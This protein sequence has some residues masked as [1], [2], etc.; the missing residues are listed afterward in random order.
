MNRPSLRFE[1]ERI[2]ANKLAEIEKQA[3]LAALRA[4][5]GHLKKAADQLGISLRTLQYR[6]IMPLCGVTFDENSVPSWTRGNFRGF[7]NAGTNPSRSARPLSL[8]IT[9]PTEGILEL[10]ARC[11]DCWIF[12]EVNPLACGPSPENRIPNA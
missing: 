3:I 6:L 10:L 5:G 4:N 2:P 9:P 1:S 8:R 11:R 12:E 7:L